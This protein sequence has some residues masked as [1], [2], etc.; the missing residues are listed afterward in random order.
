MR[1]IVVD[2]SKDPLTSDVLMALQLR[3]ANDPWLPRLRSFDCKQ[4]TETF[5]HFIPLFLSPKTTKIHIRFTEDT[6][7]MVVA[8]AM[9]RLPTLCPDLQRITL[10]DLPRDS[11]V[12]EAV[13]EMFLACNNPDALQTFEVDSPLTEEAREVVFRL[14]RLFSLWT[15]VQGPTSLPTAALP[16]LAAIDVEY[17]DDLDWLQ[18]FHGAKLEKLE[19]VAFHTE[20]DNIGDFLGAFE[21]TILATPAKNTLSELRFCTSRSWNPN[22]SSLL[23]FNQLKNVEIEFSCEGG[24]SSR[25]DDD[26]IVGLARAMPKLE[27]LQLGGAPCATRTGV[28]VKG[29]C[30]P[31]LSLPPPLR[32]LYPFSNNNSG[33]GGKRCNGTASFHRTT[34]PAGA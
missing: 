6:P 24:C 13:S 14:P 20:S 1:K 15:I 19:K 12:T 34:A 4:A 26:I 2:T 5:I 18:V 3:T 22:H 9:S 29:L 16:N 31:G 33:R 30:R 21:N 32:A 10:D 25:V 8:T 7:T 17:S 27:V 28:T 23:S 11:V